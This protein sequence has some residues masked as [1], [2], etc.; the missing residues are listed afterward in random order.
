M[1]CPDFESFILCPDFVM[2]FFIMFSLVW[3]SSGS[4]EERACC[5]GYCTLAHEYECLSMSLYLLVP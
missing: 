4:E 2:Q 5:F 1:L 3:Q